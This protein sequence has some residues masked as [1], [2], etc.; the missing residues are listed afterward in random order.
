MF[1]IKHTL[2]VLLRIATVITYMCVFFVENV[3][4]GRERER[5]GGLLMYIAVCN[6]GTH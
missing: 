4:V 6:I 1:I 2:A 5:G 3:F